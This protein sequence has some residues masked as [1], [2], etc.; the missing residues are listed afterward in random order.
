MYELDL[1]ASILGLKIGTISS[2]C[3]TFGRDCK[4]GSLQA[5]TFPAL[6]WNGIGD[7]P[8][9]EKIQAKTF[10]STISNI[11][12]IYYLIIWLTNGASTFAL[13]AKK[14]SY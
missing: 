4:L 5:K 3:D 9:F 8:R 7:D 10:H 12:F 2:L 11:T 13:K 6:N 1:I 14:F